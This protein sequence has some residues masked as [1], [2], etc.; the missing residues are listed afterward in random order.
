MYYEHVMIIND[1]VLSFVD[2]AYVVLKLH[3]CFLFILGMSSFK[4]NKA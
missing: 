3:L 1:I 4:L 2:S